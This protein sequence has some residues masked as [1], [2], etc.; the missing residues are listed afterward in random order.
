VK[1]VDIVFFVIYRYDNRNLHSTR[2]CYEQRY[3]DYFVFWKAFRGEDL[4]AYSFNFK[5]D[6]HFY[7]DSLSGPFQ[8]SY[9]VGMKKMI[10]FLSFIVFICLLSC[11]GSENDKRPANKENNTSPAPTEAS[12]SETEK[13]NIIFFGNSLSA[14][15]GVAPEE[16]FAGLIENRVDSL[17][18]PYQVI[19]A[20][21]SGETTAG[22][23]S[24]IDWILRQPVDVLILELGGNDGLRG[25]KPQAS[26]AN[27][28]SIIDKTR[29][30]YSDVRI[31][32]AGMQAPPNMG[33]D[34]TNQFRAIFP[35]LAKENDAELIPFLLEDV[36]GIPDLNLADGIHPN[37]KGHLIV[38]ENVWDVLGPM[39][40]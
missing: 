28:Q 34:F 9:F 12:K 2:V 5:A 39:L 23:A 25:I 27:L 11:G 3:S 1:H 16:S 29:A 13:K 37:P 17:G 14:G 7:S 20:G 36:G 38:A 18:L 40:K 35:K 19:N 33:S 6:F 21:L 10:P 15:Y 22:G 26:Y 24:R 32:I 31:I 8:F 30:K 4:K